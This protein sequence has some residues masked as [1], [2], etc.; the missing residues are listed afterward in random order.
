VSFDTFVSASFLAPGQCAQAND[1]L[2]GNFT[3]GTLPTTATLGVEFT[4]PDAATPIG[5]YTVTFF[6]GDPFTRQTLL[7]PSA[8][9]TGFG[10]EVEALTPSAALIDDLGLNVTL[11]AQVAGSPASAT[12]TANTL[13]CT[14]ALNPTTGTTCPV[15]ETFTP[16]SD[17]IITDTANAGA[18]ALIT[19]VTDTISQVAVT[20]P[21]PGSLGLLVSGLVGVSLLWR[22]RKAHKAD[23]VPAG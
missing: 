20:T 12:V 15:T 21:E 1:K 3:F 5:D 13:S 7:G 9:A 19:G 8:T 18:N 17:L 23:A 11:N 4:G 6:R 10:F 16:I 2:F 14:G 22:R